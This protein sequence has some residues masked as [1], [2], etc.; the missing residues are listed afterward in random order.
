MAVVE[1]DLQSLLADKDE[2]RRIVDEQY[3]EMGIVGD[4]NVTIE[5]VQEQVAEC[6]RAAGIRSE[7]N[8][9]SSAIIAARDNY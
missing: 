5:R 6:L 2:M 9:A 8:D 7:D 4:P 3:K 1:T